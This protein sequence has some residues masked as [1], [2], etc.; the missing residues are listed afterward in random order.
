M[1][2][3]RGNTLT[4]SSQDMSSPT[5]NLRVVTCQPR[6][7]NALHVQQH[8]FEIMLLHI[9]IAGMPDS[10]PV[11]AQNRDLGRCL[12]LGK[13]VVSISTYTACAGYSVFERPDN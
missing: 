8:V 9:I 4:H 11:G 2:R 3:R 7:A 5:H 12:V 1:L 6:L 10:K 13:Y